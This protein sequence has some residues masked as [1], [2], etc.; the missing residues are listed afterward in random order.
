MNYD[1]SDIKAMKARLKRSF[2]EGAGSIM[3]LRGNYFSIP[4]I[5]VKS[6]AEYIREDWNSVGNDLRY[7]MR[8]IR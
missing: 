8:K 5:S 7:A 4:S 3:S 6:D 1:Y 2:S